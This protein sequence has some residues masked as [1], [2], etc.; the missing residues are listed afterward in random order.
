MRMKAT[1][2]VSQFLLNPIA[3]SATTKVCQG[4]SLDDANASLLWVDV[5]S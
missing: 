3:T 2:S 5:L 1:K 4:Q